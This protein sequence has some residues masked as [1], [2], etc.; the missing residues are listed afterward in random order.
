MTVRLPPP[1]EHGGDAAAIARGLGVRQEDLLDLSVSLNPFAPDL[2]PLLH[3]AVER[4]VCG[5]YPDESSAL[6]V[7]ARAVGIVPERLVLTN[8]GS[9]AIAVV[10]ALLG[11]GWVQD[12]EFSLYRRAIPVLDPEGPLFRSNPHNPSGMLAPGDSSAGVW[13]EAFYPLATGRWTRGDAES[14]SR[15][16]VVG[17]LTKLLAC[18]GLRA[19][20]VICPDQSTADAVSSRR[21]AWALNAIAADCLPD[22]LDQVD[23]SSWSESIATSRSELTAVLE[24]H[25]LSVRPSDA[26]WVLVDGEADLRS[27]LAPHGVVVRDCSSFGFRGVFR[28]SV[29][30]ARGLE[31]FDLALSAALNGRKAA[32]GPGRRNGRNG[33][34]RA[35]GTLRGALLVCGTGSDVGK[36]AVVTGLC[37]L[38][39][40]SGISVAPF[41]AQNMALNSWVTDDGAEIGRAQ[42]VQAVAAGVPSEAA[43]NPILLKPTGDRHS[44]V[45]VLGE[46]WAHMDAARYHEVKTE[47]VPVVNGALADLRSRFDVVVCEGAGS[48][49]EINLLDHD[50]VNLT[51]AVRAGMPA[52]IVG[53][54]DRGGV[55]AALYGT[56]GLLPPDLR[57]AV[58]GFVINK[59]RGDPALLASGLTELERRTGLPTLGVLPWIEGVGLDAEDSLAL[60]SVPGF[61]QGDVAASTEDVLDAVVIRFPRISNFT[62]VDALALEPSVRVRMIDHPRALGDPDLIVLPGTKTTVE[63]LE[64]MRRNGL[65]DAL[66]AVA[67]R[68]GGP[69]VLGICGGYQMLGLTISDSE[70]VEARVPN[71]T[72]LGWLP[73]RTEFGVRKVVARRRGRLHLAGLGQGSGEPVEGYE[74]HHGVTVLERAATPWIRLDDGK[75]Q[76]DEGA[77]DMA[78]G[79]FGASLH[80]LLESDAARV[81]LLRMVAGRRRKRFAASGVSFARERQRRIDRLADAVEEH[82]DLDALFRIVESA[83]EPRS[84]PEVLAP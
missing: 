63:D 83:R 75:G 57:Q 44:Q 56:V 30:N 74:I 58:R 11:R 18:P 78:A 24:S 26:N 59:F 37:R 15:S 17:S 41:K 14:P 43:M 71:A 35:R 2:G 25:G 22:M 47:L 16:F 4:G 34:S 42:G 84:Q 32:T 68:D 62:D 1:G 46:P 40:R 8:G 48:P 80:G 81:A 67:R 69:V 60:G 10:A 50:I 52:V 5:S 66:E 36:S 23:L 6:V 27:L 77:A 45:V 54:I 64:W 82:L 21:P 61:S 72:G 28:V 39:A 31:R 70:G 73:A 55:L 9:E 49:A 76:S 33:A 51:L 65:A 53:D 38:M 79:V 20:Y 29:P 13:D 12:P 3:R 19:G 7:L